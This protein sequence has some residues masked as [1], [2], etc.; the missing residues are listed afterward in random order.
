[1][2]LKTGRAVKFLG[3]QHL[4]GVYSYKAAGPDI[5]IKLVELPL[6]LFGAQQLHGTRSD[7]FLPFTVSRSDTQTI[8]YEANYRDRTDCEECS[9]FS[10]ASFWKVMAFAALQAGCPTTGIRHIQ[11]C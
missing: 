3:Q 11:L 5:R 6:R 1:L 9:H 8:D 4:K 10:V 7:R 2:T